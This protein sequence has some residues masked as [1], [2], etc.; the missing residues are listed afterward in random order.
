VSHARSEHSAVTFGGTSAVPLDVPSGYRSTALRLGGKY[1][2]RLYRHLGLAAGV[3]TPIHRSGPIRGANYTINPKDLFPWV[4]FG[5]RA[6]PPFWEGRLELSAGAGGAYENVSIGNASGLFFPAAEG[7]A[8]SPRGRPWALD[9]R[10][11][12]WIGTTPRSMLVNAGGAH[13]RWFVVGSDF[14]FR[15]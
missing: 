10:R 7:E 4:Q 9:D 3:L 2:H 15:F 8:I 6:I 11:H 13:D 1:R 5:P 14:S 12:F